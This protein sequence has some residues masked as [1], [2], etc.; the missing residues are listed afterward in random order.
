MN[1]YEAQ[2]KLYIAIVCIAMTHFLKAFPIPRPLVHE[3]G[4]PIHGLRHAR[5]N[6]IGT[7]TA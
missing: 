7:P 1:G 2:K 5:D 6:I 4:M 3:K